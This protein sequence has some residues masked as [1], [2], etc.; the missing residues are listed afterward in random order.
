MCQII[1]VGHLR[2]GHLNFKSE[3]KD[4]IAYKEGLIVLSG[5]KK[6]LIPGR[7]RG[8][9]EGGR[10]NFTDNMILVFHVAHMIEH[11]GQCNGARH[12]LIFYDKSYLTAIDALSVTY[13]G[14]TV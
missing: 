13:P 1:S 11:L 9:R 10:I 8:N 14:I 7:P 12:F 5:G 3:I 4:V 2:G 6:G